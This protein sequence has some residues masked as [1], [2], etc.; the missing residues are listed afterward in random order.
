MSVT[1]I[2]RLKDYLS[3]R[4]SSKGRHCRLPFGCPG[5]VHLNSNPPSETHDLCTEW[6]AAENQHICTRQWFAACVPCDKEVVIHSRVETWQ[7]LHVRWSLKLFIDDACHAAGS[8]QIHSYGACLAMGPHGEGRGGAL[9]SGPSEIMRELNH[10]LLCREYQTSRGGAASSVWQNK[11]H[12][13]LCVLPR[14]CASR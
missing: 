7:I 4:P 3:F 11:G 10:A 1:N 12:L 2:A 9:V 8:Y 13:V 14:D 6:S 5:E